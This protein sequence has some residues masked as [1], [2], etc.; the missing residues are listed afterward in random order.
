MLFVTW[1][2]AHGGTGW[3]LASLFSS[4]S[5]GS[6]LQ[7]AYYIIEYVKWLCSLVVPC[8]IMAAL[9]VTPQHM[10]RSAMDI[11]LFWLTVIFVLAATLGPQF[12][13]NVG[14][15]PGHIVD[16]EATIHWMSLYTRVG[17]IMALSAFAI[18]AFRPTLS[19]WRS[20]RA[21]A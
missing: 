13:L 19:W 16:Y 6:G 10:H 21:T 18:A 1:D 12:Y 4:R 7:A 9:L 15:M 8:L 3:P 14:G 11:G 5:T 20:R 17:F 2:W